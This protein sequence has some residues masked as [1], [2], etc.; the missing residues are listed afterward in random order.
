MHVIAAAC[1][2]VGE[3]CEDLTLHQ[4]LDA[5]PPQPAQGAMRGSREGGARRDRTTGRQGRGQGIQIQGSTHQVASC[6][7]FCEASVSR[8]F[9]TNS[10]VEGPPGLK[11]RRARRWRPKLLSSAQACTRWKGTVVVEEA[12]LQTAFMDQGSRSPPSISPLPESMVLPGRRAELYV[13][14]HS[15]PDPY[16]ARSSHHTIVVFRLPDAGV[17]LEAELWLI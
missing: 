4:H 1:F 13:W 9:F 10:T 6:S 12:D 5:P 11:R 14:R 2:K 3:L 17:M 16:Q 15:S 8:C 7:S